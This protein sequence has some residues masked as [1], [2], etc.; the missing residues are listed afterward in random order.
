MSKAEQFW[1][2]EYKK[3]E[4]FALSDNASGD[5]EKFTRW[6]FR[7]K[8]QD[9]ISPE[10]YVL[11]IGCGNGRNILYLAEQF[12]VQGL[13]FD[14]SKEAVLQAAQRSK[15]Q[16]LSL[17]FRV[18]NIKEEI[19]LPD[20]SVDLV[21]DLMVSHYLDAE[22][23]VRFRDDVYRVLKP[24]GFLLLKSF[25]R[26]GDYHSKKMLK[27]KKQP[28]NME[29]GTYM[30][31]LIGAAEHTWTEDEVAEFWGSKFEMHKFDKSFGHLKKGRPG[32]RR[33]FVTYL[34]KPFDY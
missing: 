34:Q 28:K 22:G 13:G 9:V 12:G 4:H 27:S 3:A 24:G 33:Y 16:E 7:R 10:S 21:L 32:K 2:E 8:R 17:E 1:N 30:H 18:G 15:T 23:R 29:E 5:L 31:P 19:T 25:L 20:E 11:D 14:L 6:L 26:T